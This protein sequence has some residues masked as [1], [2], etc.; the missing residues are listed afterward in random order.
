[1]PK[2]IPTRFDV[3]DPRSVIRKA[4]KSEKPSQ[5]DSGGIKKETTEYKKMLKTNAGRK[6]KG[7]DTHDKKG[8]K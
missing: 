4:Q 7:Y 6:N 1:M 2:K 3:D 5:K 8:K